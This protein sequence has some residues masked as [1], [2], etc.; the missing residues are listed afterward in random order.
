MYTL[1]NNE[2][3]LQSRTFIRSNKLLGSFKL[4]VGTVYAAQGEIAYV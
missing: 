3:V 4:D 1:I 2:Q